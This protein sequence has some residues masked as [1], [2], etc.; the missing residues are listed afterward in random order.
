[1]N[2]N[3]HKDN[4]PGISVI[5]PVYNA[6][7][8]IGG[9]IES[10]LEQDYPRELIEII[11][12]DNNSAD[13]TREIV[14]QY[15]VIL[16]E[17]NEIQSSYAARNKGIKYAH[18]DILAFTDSDCKALKNWIA[19]GVRALEN[20][21]ADIVGG[22]VEF[23]FSNSKTAAEMYDSIIHM[24]TELNI[25]NDYAPTA[26]LFTRTSL[27]D[28]IG[29]FAEV[30]SGGDAQWTSLAVSKGC[31]L[32]YCDKAVVQH[33]TR[34][35]KELLKKRFR[36]GLG[37]VSYWRQTGMSRWQIAMIT[38]RKFLPRRPCYIRKA[39]ERTGRGDMEKKL[40]SIFWV[41]WLCNIVSALATLI[42]MLP[43]FGK[44]K[45]QKNIKR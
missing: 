23:V 43:F 6:N 29:M 7:S 25:K 45:K 1:M 28:K 3:N 32:S 38:I 27:F 22:K 5:V 10:L 36:T 31:V 40:I 18:N 33:P 21:N 30:K 16:L 34:K 2:E 14:K 24:Q 19:E 44:E 13:Q 4:L 15:P 26:N 11:I 20:S 12:V 37:T 39:I 42:S 8:G 17:E 9:L 35:L 41:A